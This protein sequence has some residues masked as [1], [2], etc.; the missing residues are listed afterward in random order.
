MSDIEDLINSVMDQDFASAGPT[1]NEIMQQKI[2]DTLDQE[3]IRVADTVFNDADP[4]EDDQE[5]DDFED[6]SDEE[7]EE[8][9]DDEDDE[10]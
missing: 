4:A 1:F 3:K 10:E 9:L 5:D 7:I 2:A 8:I 6:L